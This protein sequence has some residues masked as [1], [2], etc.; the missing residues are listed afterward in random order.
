MVDFQL[1]NAE[2][3]D[4]ASSGGNIKIKGNEDLVTLEVIGK[5]GQG[6]VSKVFH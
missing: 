4:G 6:S 2:S 3:Q 1:L 5:G